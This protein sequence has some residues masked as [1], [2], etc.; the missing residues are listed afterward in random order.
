MLS[1][2]QLEMVKLIIV[3]LI[4]EEIVPALIHAWNLANSQSVSK[5]ATSATARSVR[6]P[7]LKNRQMHAI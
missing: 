5:T 2:K 4:F 3:G 6:Q 1:R 7:V